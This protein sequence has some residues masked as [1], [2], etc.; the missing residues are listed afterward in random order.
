[1]TIDLDGKIPLA[2]LI[3]C[4]LGVARRLARLIDVDI[5][6]TCDEDFLRLGASRVACP[7]CEQPCWITP[8]F[9]RLERRRPDT[10]RIC[11]QCLV[12]VMTDLIIDGKADKV[13]NT[14]IYAISETMPDIA[15]PPMKK[16]PT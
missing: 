3:P 10:R 7:V 6:A 15:C 8:D 12:Q 11:M 14:P 2:V 16:K 13:L 9:V 5:D 4:N 1:M